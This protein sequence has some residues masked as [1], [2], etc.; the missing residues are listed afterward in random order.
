MLRGAPYESSLPSDCDTLPIE[1]LPP[2][3]L[4]EH[5]VPYLTL[6]DATR[7]Y[8]ETRDDAILRA[9]MRRVASCTSSPLQRSSSSL[10][11]T[12]GLLRIARPIRSH[13]G[14]DEALAQWVAK[15]W[16]RRKRRGS[17]D[18]TWTETL[19]R[20]VFSHC[21]ACT[22]STNSQPLCV[23]TRKN[24]SLHVVL[25]MA[26]QSKYVVNT[27]EASYALGKSE[28]YVRTYIPRC[29]NDPRHFLYFKRELMAHMERMPQWNRPGTLMRKRIAFRERATGSAQG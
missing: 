19:R 4:E 15:T 26:C 1:K 2:H 13:Q 21:W 25:C 7:W 11:A 16:Y 9:I 29:N 12:L 24:T 18:T 10:Q 5:V 8:Q 27:Y 20:C 3:V 17:N 22:H 28:Y 14:G 23:G 6:S